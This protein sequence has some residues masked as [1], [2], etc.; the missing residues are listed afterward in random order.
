[1]NDLAR[2]LR[3]HVEALYFAGIKTGEQY[4]QLAAEIIDAVY[5]VPAGGE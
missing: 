2:I 5:A 4:E 1:M 3:P